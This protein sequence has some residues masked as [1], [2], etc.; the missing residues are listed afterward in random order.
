MTYAEAREVVGY[1]DGTEIK[2][3]EGSPTEDLKKWKKGDS[4]ARN[5][6]LTALD[7]N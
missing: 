4:L 1:F 7:Y 2:P 3:A 5:I 6:F